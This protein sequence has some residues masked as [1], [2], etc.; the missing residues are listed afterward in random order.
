VTP[1][2][3]ALACLVALLPLP[4]L[5]LGVTWQCAPTTRLLCRPDGGCSSQP[6][7]IV[8]L[9]FTPADDY[10]EFCSRTLC[11]QGIVDLAREGAPDWNT[12]G[13]AMVEAL[14]LTRDYRGRARFAAFEV[15]D[16]RFV[17]SDLGIDGQDTTWFDCRQ[18]D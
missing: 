2:R 13:V 3:L 17:L 11:W 9:R 6:P 14:P 12:L 8:Q 7:E 5:A 18:A 4:A 16:R 15:N 10:L 1:R